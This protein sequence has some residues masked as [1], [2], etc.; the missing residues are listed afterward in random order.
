MRVSFDPV[1]EGRVSSSI[2]VSRIVRLWPSSWRNADPLERKKMFLEWRWC[3]SHYGCMR[4]TRE[5]RSR[6]NDRKLNLERKNK[7][8]TIS[9]IRTRRKKFLSPVC[10]IGDENVESK[11]RMIYS[12]EREEG[13]GESR[14]RI[15]RIKIISIRFFFHENFFFP[16][17][18]VSDVSERWTQRVGSTEEEAWI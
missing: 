3:W 17:N 16:R 5:T 14:I 15:Q 2:V 12:R 6:V 7:N 11:C 13:G 18:F 9:F 1:T 10:D 4:F 8:R